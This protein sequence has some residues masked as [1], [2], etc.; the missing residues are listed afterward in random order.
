MQPKLAIR[1][2]FSCRVAAKNTSLSVRPNRAGSK[3]PLAVIHCTPRLGEQRQERLRYV[4]GAEQV[5]RKALLKRASIA[6]VIVECYAGVVDQQVERID[7]L[8]GGL[9]LRRVGHVQGQRRYPP[10]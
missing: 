7:A 10:I 8:H 2:I 1:S 6:E 4:V 3:N 9:D 5:D